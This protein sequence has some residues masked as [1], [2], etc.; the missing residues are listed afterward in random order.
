MIEWLKKWAHAHANKNRDQFW[1]EWHRERRYKRLVYWR[2]KREEARAAVASADS[3][4]YYYESLLA[5]CSTAA[6]SY[7][8]DK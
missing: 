1:R 5:E 8:G 4:I 6:P 3:A 7:T 2:N